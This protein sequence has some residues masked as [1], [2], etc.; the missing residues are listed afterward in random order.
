MSLTHNPH[1]RDTNF[2][3]CTSKQRDNATA[4][5]WIPPASKA[6]PK[7]FDSPNVS[8]RAVAGT[9]SASS[10]LGVLKDGAFTKPIG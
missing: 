8:I 1:P 6:D 2:L 7:A 5:E 4:S 9:Y 10:F 3:S